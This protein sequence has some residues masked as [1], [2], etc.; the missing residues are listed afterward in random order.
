MVLCLCLAPLLLPL[1]HRALQFGKPCCPGFLLQRLDS[2]SERQVTG[3]CDQPSRIPC[4][5][6]AI[7][8]LRQDLPELTRPFSMSRLRLKTSRSTSLVSS[9]TS[10]A[11]CRR[12][13]QVSAIVMQRPILHPWAAIPVEEP[14]RDRP[15][16]RSTLLSLPDAARF[17]VQP[18]PLEAAALLAPCAVPPDHW[19]GRGAP[20]KA[21]RR[22]AEGLRIVPRSRSSAAPYEAPRP[23]HVLHAAW[24]RPHRR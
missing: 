10:S 12:F 15:A 9:A 6:G 22:D 19:R 2:A 11:V 23:D 8:H 4:L 3:M 16:N 13:S 14:S 18:S 20:R 5:G 21:G 17:R 1:R 7:P 24:R